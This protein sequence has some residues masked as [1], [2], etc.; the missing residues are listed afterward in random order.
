M[1]EQLKDE[2]IIGP[3]KYYCT[4]RAKILNFSI[5]RWT[6]RHK[7]LYNIRRNYIP[8]LTLF[9]KILL[10][11]VE[12]NGLNNEKEVEINGL[13]QYIQYADI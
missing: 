2:E 7:A 6:V 13:I 11:P 9:A 12:R 3:C 5:K 4:L 8:L 1:L 10:D